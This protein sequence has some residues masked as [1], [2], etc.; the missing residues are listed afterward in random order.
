MSEKTTFLLAAVCLLVPA[1]GLTAAGLDNLTALMVDLPGWE[2]G[3]ADGADMT[4]QGMRAV[5]VS[6]NYQNGDRTFDA[7]ILI[8][9]QASSAWMP[10]YREG[11]KVESPEGVMEVKR[12]NGFLAY[13]MFETEGGS[14]GIVVLL[15]E[16]TKE[17]DPGAVF[18]VSFEGMSR[19]EAMQ[20]AQ[21]F[22]WA[23]MKEQVSRLK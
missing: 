19:E 2:A 17:T 1:L 3:E 18:A 9:T 6:R 11:Y 5:T 4:Y 14:G 7:S 16:A 13:E 10:S 12:I 20:I 15:L 21:R 8:G 23:R 22:A